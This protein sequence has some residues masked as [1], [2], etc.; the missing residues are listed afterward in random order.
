[1][2]PPQTIGEMP[3]P[4][5]A[6]VA[7][8]GLSPDRR[9]MGAIAPAP[10][11]AACPAGV[12]VKAYVSLIAEG[13]FAEALE[14]VRRHCTLPSV[15]GRV[16][17]APCE[18]AC[19]RTHHDDPLAI[20]SLKRFVSDVVASTPPGSPEPPDRTERVAVVGSG[21][22]GLT[23]AFDLR[24]AGFPVT[25]L[26]AMP[27]AGGML[28]YGI[29][30]Y[31][32]PPDVLDAEIA[33]VLAAGIELSTDTP[34]PDYEAV[35]GLLANGFSAVLL[36]LGAQNG[37]LLGIDGEADT[38]ACEDALGFLR[39]VN[40][41][42]HSPMSGTVLVVGGG[43][44]AIEA[45]RSALRLGAT[46]VEV[47]YRRSRA[48]L[49]AGAEEVASAEAEGVTFLFLA[50]P[51]RVVHHEGALAGLEC[52]LVR[53]GAPDPEGRPVPEPMPG[54]EFSIEA[55]HVLVAVG[56]SADLDRIAG[57][58]AGS[59]LDHGLLRTDPATAMT[60][61]WG[62]FAAG[63]VV[64]GPSTVIEA[65]ASG[66]EAAASIGHYLDTGTPGGRPSSS[67]PWTELGFSDPDPVD[68]ARIVPAVR[69]I[70][71]GR[72][73]AEVE[74]AYSAAE[75]ITEASR[76]LRCGP[77]SEC[78]ACAP[79]CD[80][81]HLLMRTA[82]SA[83]PTWIPLRVSSEVA[84]ELGTNGAV[85]GMMQAAST[86]VDLDLRPMQMRYS[87]ELCRGC[88]RCIEVCSF[89]AFQRESTESP[90]APV[91]FDPDACRGCAL[92]GAVCPTGALTPVAHSA[93]WWDQI[94]VPA[95]GSLMLTCD[96]GA[97]PR[98]EGDSVV[99]CRCVGQAHPGMVL[100]LFR[101]GV[102][103][104]TVVACG[105]CRFGAGRRLAAQHIAE[106]QAIL[107]ALGQE[108]SSVTLAP[109]PSAL[110]LA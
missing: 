3:L 31:R 45:A 22:A 20:R 36:A 60:A 94:E 77:C 53:L 90:D 86:G 79:G 55:D 41:G 14:E 65:I 48:E 51:Q 17:H 95:A 100:D 34:I 39:R 33:T 66:H 99:T 59:F 43:S 69:P 108:G 56:Q 11:T 46:S 71:V 29:A 80:R 75:A 28:R 72:E 85:P 1:M 81:R 88:A 6:E 96:T 64:T 102:E 74:E 62:L 107:K 68:S 92:C 23:A 35:A 61:Q 18:P 42:D 5:S 58:A 101:R 7:I 47:V 26:E 70:A 25:L 89:D 30:D 40:T 2:S 104:L 12:N 91:A 9:A 76:C 19:R 4:S 13:R 87:A 15:C 54:T 32:L 67:A 24:R 78:A 93:E 37:R 50:A 109:V 73:F 57:D 21:P 97:P 98:S 110:E 83:A 8:P 106:S 82:T 38:V 16:C 105:Q 44:T 52:L 27:K 84:L 103:Q 10:C 63:D 49:R